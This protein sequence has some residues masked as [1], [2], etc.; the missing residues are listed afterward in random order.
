MIWCAWA[1]SL[2][3]GDASIA[4]RYQSRLAEV[5]FQRDHDLAGK[6]GDQTLFDPGLWSLGPVKDARS[7]GPGAG[8]TGEAVSD[9]LERRVEKR[10][11]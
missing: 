6:G 9:L 4:R 2:K 1:A 8:M 5:A 3:H 7:A 11:S 10:A